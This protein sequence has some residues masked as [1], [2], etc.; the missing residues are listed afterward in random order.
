MLQDIQQE[1]K[2]YLNY[3]SNLFKNTEI[4]AVVVD[5]KGSDGYVTYASGAPMLKN[6]ILQIMQFPTL[7]HW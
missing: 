3:L 2:K 7:M 1:L 6:I 5:I 4:N